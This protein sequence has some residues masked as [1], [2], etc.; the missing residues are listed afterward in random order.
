M[1]GGEFLLHRNAFFMPLP[2]EP[3]YKPYSVQGRK[4]CGFPSLPELSI[5]REDRTD[6][7]LWNRGRKCDYRDGNASVS[8]ITQPA[9]SMLVISKELWSLVR[10][11]WNSYRDNENKLH[12]NYSK[13]GSEQNLKKEAFA[14]LTVN[15][16]A[17]VVEEVGECESRVADGYWNRSRAEQCCSA[18]QPW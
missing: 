17:K 10:Q 4:C 1:L 9:I 7:V 8:C 12:G 6:E 5:G 18:A 15:G 13:C 14:N 11:V 16:S 2:M 3:G